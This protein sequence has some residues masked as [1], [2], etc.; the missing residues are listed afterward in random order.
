VAFFAADHVAMTP[1]GKLYV[2]GGFFELLRFPSFPA[3][4]P[5]L[6]M[7][8]VFEIPFHQVMCDHVITVVLRDPEGR[9]LPVQIQANFRSAPGFDTK[10]GDPSLVPFGVTVT[11]VQFPMAGNY[12]LALSLDGVELR[13]YR[14]RAVQT[15]TVASEGSM[16]QPDY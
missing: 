1:D 11:N 12:H 8:A 9:D 16:H 7:A 4:L 2:N 14:I 5:S 6:G 10:F 15:P 3:F 13:K